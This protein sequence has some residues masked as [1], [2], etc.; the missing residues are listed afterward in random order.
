MDKVLDE[1]QLGVYNYAGDDALAVMPREPGDRPR[2]G[3]AAYS[4]PFRIEVLEVQGERN[5]RKPERKCAQA[6]IGSG[7]GTA[8][9]ADRRVASRRRAHGDRRNGKQAH[10]SASPK[11]CSIRKSRAARRRP[12]WSSRSNCRRATSRRSRRSKASFAQ[13]VPGR[14]VKFKFN[15]LEHAAGKSQRRGGVQ[16]AVDSVRKNNEIWELNMRLTLDEDNHSLESHRDWALQN[17]SYL[18]D[19]DGKT[20][21]NGGF[22]PVVQSKNE[23]GLVYYFDAAEGLGRPDL[24]LRNAGRHRRAPDRLRAQGHRTPVT[25]A[26]RR[27]SFVGRR[28]NAAALLVMLDEHFFHRPQKR[29]HEQRYAKRGAGERILTEAGS[30]AEGGGEP[31]RAGGRE[32][33]DF[34]LVARA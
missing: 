19:K 4:G 29:Q 20:I 33:F 5:R 31:D 21:D 18:E 3:A 17:V 34:L 10:R 8:V 11:R 13:L 16:V 30:H 25:C 23:V 27:Q 24:G 2:Y 15:D 1:V 22:E 6:E 12:S 28:I 9:A 26:S 7:M 32:P 14:R